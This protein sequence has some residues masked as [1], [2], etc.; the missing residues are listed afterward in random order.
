MSP[1]RTI[2]LMAR[3]CSAAAALMRMEGAIIMS[4][5]MSTSS[6]ISSWMVQP[7]V[8]KASSR[9]SGSAKA[10]RPVAGVERTSPSWTTTARGA[11]GVE[12]AGSE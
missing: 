1:R 10:Y 2:A 11:S 3:S 7:V 6:L 8:R 9:A 5:A 12:S 4:L